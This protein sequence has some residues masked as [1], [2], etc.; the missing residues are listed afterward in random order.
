MFASLVDALWCNLAERAGA[1]R[2][3]LAGRAYRYQPL[4]PRD[5]QDGV[6]AERPPRRGI[7]EEVDVVVD[8]VRGARLRE[9]GVQQLGLEDLLEGVKGQPGQ[10]ALD[11]VGPVLHD[12]F[13]LN[14]P[15]RALPAGDEVKHV[16][17]FRRLAFRLA[18]GARQ[19]D[20][21]EREDWLV[22][23]FV[24]HLHQTGVEVDLRREGGDRQQRRVAH[25]EERGDGFVEEAWVDVRGLLENDDVPARSLRGRNLRVA[26]GGW[27]LA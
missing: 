22:G 16:H 9:H 18:G 13:E 5:A 6:V 27:W 10:L 26:K 20:A 19:L 21:Q 14:V 12:R 3:A 8:D 7:D 23:D 2:R 24:P 17:A 25:D 1:E 4:L 11:E 15:V